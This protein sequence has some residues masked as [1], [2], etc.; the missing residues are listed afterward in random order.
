M[1]HMLGDYCKYPVVT[2]ASPV[3]V[4]QCR[5]LSTSCSLFIAGNLLAKACVLFPKAHRPPLCNLLPSLPTQEVGAPTLFATHFHELTALQ[6]PVGVANMHVET[7]TD[8]AT[9]KLTMLYKVRASGCC[10][11]WTFW[12]RSLS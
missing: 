1:Q 11:D 10:N 4:W 9:G 7:A 8:A 12:Y 5:L 6:G 2:T 3:L